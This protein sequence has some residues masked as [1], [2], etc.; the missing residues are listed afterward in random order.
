VA[1]MKMKRRFFTISS[2]IILWLILEPIFVRGLH[3]ITLKD[4]GDSIQ[5]LPFALL[6]P[7]GFINL[8]GNVNSTDFPKTVK[9]IIS[10]VGLGIY[11]CGFAYYLWKCENYKRGTYITFYLAIMVIFVLSMK[12][13]AKMTNDPHFLNLHPL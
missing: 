7:L 8:F 13:C 1:E 6:L 11:G 10:M 3:L 2:V 9:L 5:T 12:G 4:V